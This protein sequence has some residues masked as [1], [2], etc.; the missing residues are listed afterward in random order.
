MNEFYEYFCG[1]NTKV[2]LVSKNTDGKDNIFDDIVGINYSINYNPQPVYGYCSTYFDAVLKGR[3]L[4]QGTILANANAD[5]GDLIKALIPEETLKKMRDTNRFVNID[6]SAT[7][8]FD[9]NID[10]GSSVQTTNSCI[11]LKNCFIISKGRSI[12]SNADVIVD[13]YNFFSRDIYKYNAYE[14]TVKIIE[15]QRKAEESKPIEEKNKQNFFIPGNNVKENLKPKE[16]Q[17]NPSG[18]YIEPS[19]I[20]KLEKIAF[21]DENNESYDISINKEIDIFGGAKVLAYKAPFY[22]KSADKEDLF[23]QKVLNA[24]LINYLLDSLN[25][26]GDQKIN[27]PSFIKDK[28]SIELFIAQNLKLNLNEVEKTKQISGFTWSI[29]N[30]LKSNKQTISEILS[31]DLFNLNED[32]SKNETYI[33]DYKIKKTVDSFFD[34]NYN[35]NIGLCDK[36]FYEGSP[37]LPNNINNVFQDPLYIDNTVFYLSTDYQN[38]P[39]YIGVNF[40]DKKKQYKEYYQNLWN[41]N[42]EFIKG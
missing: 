6:Y 3:E 39:A 16:S 4:I 18:F 24:N 31:F 36:F 17:L 9:I 12:Q 26:Y 25:R 41:V 7:L 10:F 1:A 35:N 34:G 28:K 40:L 5:R 32:Y 30:K 20:E 29:L 38:E 37:N 14:K 2:S 8:T 23:K 33:T 15:M 42:P 22:A 11:V 21:A 19:K 27:N 13:E